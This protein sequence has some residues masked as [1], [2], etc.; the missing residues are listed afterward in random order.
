MDTLLINGNIYLE[1]ER[2]AQS[3]LI[4]GDQIIKVGSNEEVKAAADEQVTVVDLNGKTVIPGF[5]DSHLHLMG[6]AESLAQVMLHNS[7]SI[8]EVLERAR[9]FVD[10]NKPTPGKVILGRG[11]NQDYFTDE[12]RVLTR[13][14]LDKISTENPII[15]TRT[16]GHILACNTK[17]LEVA[18][19]TKDSAQIPGGLFE[20]EADGTPNGVFCEFAQDLINKIVPAPTAEEHARLLENAMNYASQNGIT[21]LQTNDLGM[22]DYKSL[23]ATYQSLYDSDKAA[24]RTYHQCTFPN[25][26]KFK[27]FIAEGNI[28]GAGSDYHKIGPLKLFLDGSL[29]ARTANMRKDYFDAPG[30]R[31]IE[32]LT[33]ETVNELVKIANDNN[34]QA[35]FHAIGDGAIDMALKAYETVIENGHNPNRF[36]IIHCQITDKE[37]LERFKKSDILAYVQPIFIHYDMHMVEDRVGKELAST[38]YAFGTLGRMGVH[39]AYGTDCPVEDLNP[40]ENIYC[41]VTRKDLTGKPEGGFYADEKVDIYTAID[42]YTVGSAFASFE[43]NKKGRIAEGFMADLTVLDKNIFTIDPMEIKDVKAVT[44]IMGGKVR[45]SQN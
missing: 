8:A 24:V 19:I 16:C 33:Q 40:F 34:M 31:G 32:C 26:E 28:T 44:T 11:W 13:H 10:A 41:A 43:E 25:A 2:F 5:V 38:S 22:D 3:V 35:A 15:F 36:G 17:A 4:R 23:Y 6:L 1:R 20:T 37:M 29:G 21:S 9:K 18:G 7:K 45:Y 14:D 30:Q 39:V 42:N 12:K 27:Q